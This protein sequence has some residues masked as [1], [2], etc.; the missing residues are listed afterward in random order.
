[1]TQEDVKGTIIV[2]V[3]ETHGCVVHE[4]GQAW[5]IV[6]GQTS[7]RDELSTKVCPMAMFSLYPTTYFMR[8]GAKVPWFKKWEKGDF[9]RVCCPDEEN[10][11]V[12]EIRRVS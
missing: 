9:Y 12:F 11:V 4:V 7:S 8:F 10:R 1:M 6:P 3:V 2:S 5:K